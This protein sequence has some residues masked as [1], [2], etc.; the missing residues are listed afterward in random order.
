MS[1]IAV[2][3][4][5]FGLVQGISFRAA[6]QQEAERLG[7]RGWVSN[8]PDD[9]VAGLFEGPRDA[10][11]QLVAWCRSGPPGAQVERVD[12]EETETSGASGFVTR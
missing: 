11:D 4:Q 3:V 8:E 10:V 6:C 9:S 12:V 5:V 1:D 2:S 7:V